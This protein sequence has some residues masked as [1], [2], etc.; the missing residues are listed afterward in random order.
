MITPDRT[1]SGV[2]PAYPPNPHVDLGENVH[3]GEELNV[4]QVCSNVQKNRKGYCFEVNSLSL[5]LIGT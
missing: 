4:W 2:R 3:C 1:L 5:L